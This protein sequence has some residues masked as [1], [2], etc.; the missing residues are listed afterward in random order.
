MRRIRE[1][2][3]EVVLQNAR[4]ARTDGKEGGAIGDCPWRLFA[5]IPTKPHQLAVACAVSFVADVDNVHQLLAG[6][7]Q[8]SRLRLL[9]SAPTPRTLLG[10]VWTLALGASLTTSPARVLVLLLL[11]LWLCLRSSFLAP[12]P[13]LSRRG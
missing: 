2:L 12:W 10:F 11:L 1:L 5:G 13:L 4:S 3:G 6:H 7:F 9:G 8:S